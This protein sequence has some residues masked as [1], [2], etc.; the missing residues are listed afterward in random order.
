MI[1]VEMEMKVA[2]EGEAE[3]LNCATSISQQSLYAIEA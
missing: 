1:K 2:K 3:A